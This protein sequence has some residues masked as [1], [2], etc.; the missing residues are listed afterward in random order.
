[1]AKRPELEHTP[2]QALQQNRARLLSSQKNINKIH[3]NDRPIV[4]RPI[5][6]GKMGNTPQTDT[7]AK[8]LTGGQGD[9]ALIEGR[10][11]DALG[12][13][14]ARVKREIK[15]Q[16]NLGE[17]KAG[18]SDT[19]KSDLTIPITRAKRM[20]TDD[21]RTSFH[22]SH[23]S[24][25]KTNREVVSES[26]RA[27]RPGAAK[28]H[29]KY[30]ERDSAVAHD[31]DGVEAVAANDDGIPEAEAVAVND[32]GGIAAAPKELQ[33][34]H[35]ENGIKYGTEDSRAA[36]RAAARQLRL[37]GAGISNEFPW[38]ERDPNRGPADRAYGL[39]DLSPRSL[40]HHGR[41]AEMLLHGD[42]SPVVG[43]GGET[44][45]S[46]RSQGAGDR[47]N[48][49]EG[50]RWLKA[51]P[52]FLK[53][54]P[55]GHVA[56]PLMD[57]PSFVHPRAEPV[58][59]SAAPTRV[60]ANDPKTAEGQGVYIERQ[61]AL[62]I[63]PDGSRVLYTNIDND[64]AERAEFWRL[65]E[66][67]EYD[68]SPDKITFTINKNPEFW[69]RAA[70]HSECPKALSEAVSQADPDKKISVNTGDNVAM[71]AF[72]SKIEGWD[73]CK[74]N[75]GEDLNEYYARRN[76]QSLAAFQDGRGGRV[77]FRII[78]ELPYE[79]D[80][81][82]RAS[83][84]KSFSQE[85]EKR[86]LPFVAVM[87]APDHTN[88][89]KNWHF[90]LVYY[91]R[92]CRRLTADDLVAAPEDKNE[93]N[94]IVQRPSENDIGK[95]DFTVVERYKTSSRE[96]RTRY[97]FAQKKVA[98]VA[99]DNKWIDIL[100]KQ[101]ATI[102]N[103][104][105]QEAGIERRLDHRTHEEMGIHADPQEHLGTRLANM[106]A[107]GI[108]TPKGVSN[109]ERQWTAVLAKLD[110]D[111]DWRKNAVD[112]QAT[113]WLKQLEQSGHGEDVRRNVRG[114]ITRWHQHRI[115]AEE[116]DAI[117]TNVQ[118]HM[119]RLTS[120]AEKVLTTCRKHLDAIEKGLA[121]KYQASR[122]DKLM[123]KANE[124]QDWLNDIGVQLENEKTLSRDARQA[125]ERQR[126]LADV[127]ENSIERSL[128]EGGRGKA[129]PKV[130]KVAANDQG[131]ADRD[132]ASRRTV[133]NGE[134]EAWIRDIVDQRRRLKRTDRN[135]HPANMT[136]EDKA[137]VASTNYAGV[138]NRLVKLKEGQDR[139][140]RD[141]AKF[142][143][144]KPEA[145]IRQRNENE[146]RFVLIG[147]RPAL[148]EAFADYQADPILIAARDAA[149]QAQSD[150]A[151]DRQRNVAANDR[152]EDQRRERAEQRR[153]EREAD[154]R[155]I[156]AEEEQ[157]VRAARE[158]QPAVEEERRRAITR[159]RAISEAIARAVT[160]GPKRVFVQNGV[161]SLSRADMADIRATAEQIA[162]AEIQKRLVSI[163][164]IQDREI[165]RLAG[166]VRAKPSQFVEK[167]GGFILRAGVN[168]DVAGIARRWQNNQVVADELMAIR[169]DANSRGR[170]PALP[171]DT[172]RR[173]APVPSRET[174]RPVAPAPER[175]Q[176]PER[177]TP[178]RAPAPA[179][180]PRREAPE[181]PVAPRPQ[182]EEQR[183]APTTPANE[184]ITTLAP[185]LEMREQARKH[186]EERRIAEEAAEA[187]R[188]SKRRPIGNNPATASER[189]ARTEAQRTA[190]LNAHP[191]IAQ[192]NK[193]NQEGNTEERRR[194]SF[195]IVNDRSAR[196]E[197]Q[198]LDRNLVRRIREEAD[199]VRD[200]R[201]P[202]LGLD[203][204]L[205][206]K[207]DD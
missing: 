160:N 22:F 80:I 28:A 164:A 81:A 88:S 49:G 153:E 52:A 48:P 127:L 125:S 109:E 42:A 115:E 27:N 57:V 119:E 168:S 176:A 198:K 31:Q 73:P 82:G 202:S 121:S 13:K 142:I 93:K 128:L 23:D 36:S 64:P 24:V 34:E 179:A 175:P 171:L 9:N 199:R 206:P 84:L 136:D 140:I 184:R 167:E 40:V 56:K 20:T 26:G 205:A 204:G 61:E 131:K 194:I 51:V 187:L 203:Q 96:I 54:R 100:R 188:N 155:R 69:Q 186:A 29:N 181:R 196:V 156:A 44:D 62:A 126:L 75:E 116:Q 7:A 103:D 32:N 12:V 120:R 110:R 14:H 50:R 30:I 149:L 135:I 148:K 165:K 58:A 74:R 55:P 169:D 112:R 59:A 43:R 97:P 63:Q 129:A 66:E 114:S 189:V 89:D 6:D 143:E 111:L 99:Q 161:A 102:T 150:L 174:P 11:D 122:E 39:H 76:Q 38:P 162:D 195:E 41:E 68:A 163:A 158:A 2:T 105:L 37:A 46:V 21:G 172:D 25:A 70:A 152:G 144:Q 154:D 166:Y 134:I 117:A 191:L 107:M 17:K 108:A 15:A 19:R 95:W 159:E 123:A 35:Q 185:D 200:E 87:H 124:A 157:R 146:T 60:A 86:K 141:V 101:L 4:D 78:G 104:H 183:V 65:V 190:S 77:Q 138:R 182:R 53:P 145:I 137:I 85:F 130:E 170:Q 106:E 178:V 98:Q 1:M 72:L 94:K 92:P 118:E 16:N 193:A 207:R 5:R 180:D 173:A 18:R 90:H 33:D 79:L 71:R 132:A 192:W 3:S 151:A 45:P 139:I 83:I 10:S 147:A 91:D 133:V 197:L 47:G 113:K 8:V 177:D 201:Q 67:H